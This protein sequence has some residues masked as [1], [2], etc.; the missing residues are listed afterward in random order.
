MRPELVLRNLRLFP[1]PEAARDGPVDVAIG[2]GRILEIAP[3]IEA[4]APSEDF[5]GRLAVPGFVESHVHLDKSCLL[6]RV[7]GA[8]DL[9]SA[10]A[11]VSAAKSG[12]SEEDVFARGARTLEK[13]IAQGTTRM[14]TH[15]EADPRIGLR[16]FHAVKALKRD[17]AWAMDL[18]I[19]VFPQ[20]GLTNDPGTDPLLVEACATGAEVIGGCP[21][22]DDDPHAQIARIFDLAGEFDLD[23][24][25]HLDFHLD[26]ARMDLGEIC[27]VTEARR[28]GG[29]VAVGHVSALSALPPSETQAWARRM[30]DVGVA[31]T[32]LPSTDLFLMG[33]EHDHLTPRGVAPAHAFHAEGCRCSLATNNVLNPFTPFGDGSLLRM[34]NLYANAAQLGSAEAF[35]TCLALVTEQPAALMNLAD[36][37]LAPGKAADLAILDAP[38]A[39]AAVAELAPPVAV[40]RAGRRTVTRDAPVLHRP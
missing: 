38:S 4:E 3:G 29:R 1:G 28:W 10:I 14:R 2:A 36:Y 21:Y 27:R 33:R 15:V 37:G 25:F 19:C 20:E 22:T 16:G 30:A 11:A 26:P 40:Y 31:L 18:Q 5:G 34:A 39:E 12:W 8:P 23:V 13:C 35:R 17:Y 9:P 32:V 24:D 6:D 7:G